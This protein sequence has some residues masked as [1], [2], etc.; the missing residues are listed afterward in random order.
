[1]ASLLWMMNKNW[2]LVFY[3]NKYSIE[4]VG[5]QAKQPGQ[6]ALVKPKDESA[7]GLMLQAINA[8]LIMLLI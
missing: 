7:N 3:P 8:I 1:M 6:N 5:L 4:K 2:K